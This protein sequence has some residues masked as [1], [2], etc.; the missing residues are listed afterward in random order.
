LLGAAGF[1]SSISIWDWQ[2]KTLEATLPSSF[3]ARLQF[4]PD[5]TFAATSSI[6][7]F[8]LWETRTSR[9]L[10]PRYSLQI[11]IPQFDDRQRWLMTTGEAI[12]LWD[13]TPDARQTDD[14]KDL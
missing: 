12:R 10:G 11:Q 7:Q 8:A 6:S 4:S 2:R 13:I 5:A 9:V 3:I 14:L 1:S